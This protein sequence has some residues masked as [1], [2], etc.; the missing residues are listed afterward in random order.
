[1]LLICV[2]TLICRLHQRTLVT[3]GRLESAPESAHFTNGICDGSESPLPVPA[4]SIAQPH[5]VPSSH[6][7]PLSAHDVDLPSD[8]ALRDDGQAVTSDGSDV[9]NGNYL[10]SGEDPVASSLTPTSLS[11]EEAAQKPYFFDTT[12]SGDES[13]TPATQPVI[14]SGETVQSRTDAAAEYDTN[15][16]QAATP[17]EESKSDKAVYDKQDMSALEAG[18]K[19]A[20]S[21][22]ETEVSATSV[23]VKSVTVRDRAGISTELTSTIS[24]K[25][26][27]QH[28]AETTSDDMTRVFPDTVVVTEAEKHAKPSSAANVVQDAEQVTCSDAVSLKHV[29]SSV[30]EEM[31]REVVTDDHAVLKPESVSAD[32]RDDGL[33]T[34]PSNDI[35]H[36]LDD[37]PVTGNEQ[38]DVGQV[39]A[40]ETPRK[41][42]KRD[43]VGDRTVPRVACVI[44]SRT[45]AEPLKPLPSE[46]TGVQSVS[47]AVKTGAMAAVAAPYLAGKAIAD[48]LRSDTGQTT[49]V[50][51]NDQRLSEMTKT[52]AEDEQR[53]PFKVADAGTSRQLIRD[54]G[55]RTVP[56]HQVAGVVP[57]HVDAEPG[58]PLP[59]DNDSAVRRDQDWSRQAGIMA[60]AVVDETMADVD[61]V[62]DSGE[63]DLNRTSDERRPSVELPKYDDNLEDEKEESDD[64]D[65]D[66]IDSAADDDDDTTSTQMAP[67]SVK[68][69]ETAKDKKSTATTSTVVCARP[70]RGSGKKTSKA[71]SGLPEDV[72]GTEVLYGDESDKTKEGGDRLKHAFIGDG[73]EQKMTGSADEKSPRSEHADEL[74]QTAAVDFTDQDQ[75]FVVDDQHPPARH[76]KTPDDVSTKE[77]TVHSPTSRAETVSSQGIAREI[78]V[79]TDT[80]PYTVTE[81]GNNSDRVMEQ[82]RSDTATAVQGTEP[83]TTDHE[84]A[85]L[86]LQ[87]SDTE[88]EQGDRM[89]TPV[90]AAAETSALPEKVAGHAPDLQVSLAAKTPKTPDNLPA[91]PKQSVREQV[92]SA[93]ME[94]QQLDN[95]QTEAELA[96]LRPLEIRQQVDADEDKKYGASER[97]RGTDVAGG[98]RSVPKDKADN[99]GIQS[100]SKAVKTGAMAAVAAPYL[101]G[102]AIADALRSDTGSATSVP[103]NDQRLSETTKTSAEEQQRKPSSIGDDAARAFESHVAED[104]LR[105]SRLPNQLD[106]DVE[107]QPDSAEASDSSKTTVSSAESTNADVILDTSPSSPY[108]ASGISEVKLQQSLMEQA[109]AVAAGPDSLEVHD[110]RSAESSVKIEPLLP[111]VASAKPSEVT[112]ASTVPSVQPLTSTLVSEPSAIALSVSSETV[113]P[114]ISTVASTVQPPKTV[115]PDVSIAADAALSSETAKPVVSVTSTVPSLE[116][117]QPIISTAAPTLPYSASMQPTVST[118]AETVQPVVTTTT[119]AVPLSV[120]AEPFVSTTASAVQS[121]DTSKPIVSTVPMSETMQP[122]LSTTTSTVSSSET[123][124]PIVSTKESP[125]LPSETVQPVISAVASTPLPPDTLQAVIST[126]P[127][128]QQPTVTTQSVLPAP[129]SSHVSPSTSVSVVSAL[130]S[131]VSLQTTTDTTSSFLTTASI[132]SPVTSAIISE[133]F[134]I[135]SDTKPT[136]VVEEMPS[137]EMDKSLVDSSAVAAPDLRSQPLLSERRKAEVGDEMGDVHLE[138]CRQRAVTDAEWDE[139]NKARSELPVE[140]ASQNIGERSQPENEPHDSALSSVKTA[141]KMG[142]LGIVGAPV[143]AGKAIAEAVKSKTAEEQDSQ[144]RRSPE[145]YTEPDATKL[146]KPVAPLDQLSDD[147]SALAIT[148]S[149]DTRPSHKYTDTLAAFQAEELQPQVVSV[150]SR[151]VAGDQQK[152]LDADK[153]AKD[154]PEIAANQPTVAD[155][156]RSDFGRSVESTSQPGLSL[157]EA[158]LSR[159][160]DQEHNCFIDPSTG[161]RISLA[162]AVQ[163]GLIDGS[164]KVIA[165]LNSGE[166]ISVVEALSRGIIDPETGMV[167]V[168]GEAVVPLN[169]ALASGLIMDDTDGELLELAASIGAAAGRHAWNEA[170]DTA[171]STEELQK[172]VRSHR[173][174]VARQSSQPL[175]LVQMLDLGLYDPVSGEFRD[176]QTSDSL[177]LGEAIRWRLL[178]KNSV[179]INDPQS[180]EVLSLEESVRGGL[181]SG[182][183]SLVHD[184]STSENIPLTEA[185]RRGILVPRPMSI[186]TAINIG[187]YDEANGMFFDPTNGLYFALEEAVEGGLIDPHSLVIDPATGKAMAVAAALACGILDARHGNVVNIH[188]GEVIPLK[189]MA[190]SS[191]AVIGSQPVGISNQV[192]TAPTSVEQAGTP[193]SGPDVHEI[194]ESR[195]ISASESSGDANTGIQSL[196]K[197]IKTGALAAVAAPY[198]AG[199]AIADALRSDRGLT[200]GD[201]DKTHDVT[202][203][204]RLAT[205]SRKHDVSPT[206]QIND[207]PDMAAE[208]SDTSM[209]VLQGDEIPH[210][211]GL[212]RYT[213][214]APSA[215]A[216]PGE[217]MN[218]DVAPAGTDAGKSWLAET[219]QVQA[220]LSDYQPVSV[221]AE[222][223]AYHPTGEVIAPPAAPDASVSDESYRA[224]AFDESLTIP[225]GDESSQ[226]MKGQSAFDSGLPVSNV[227]GPTDQTIPKPFVSDDSG[228]PVSA[229]VSATTTS[230]DISP[231]LHPSI[232]VVPEDGGK[233]SPAVDGVSSTVPLQQILSPAA[234]SDSQVEGGDVGGRDAELQRS[235]EAE[236]LHDA[237]DISIAQKTEAENSRL[238]PDSMHVTV[239][240]DRPT[241][242]GFTAAKAPGLGQP[243][244]A[245]GPHDIQR[246][247]EMKHIEVKHVPG[248]VTRTGDA[249]TADEDRDSVSK[250]VGE[251]DDGTKDAPKKDVQK[252]ADFRD[253]VQPVT[254]V[255]HVDDEKTV[256]DDV[257]KS[258]IAKKVEERRDHVDEDDLK[259]DGSKKDIPGAMRDAPCG[260]E[261]VQYPSDVQIAVKPLSG[262]SVGIDA[263]RKGTQDGITK[264]KDKDVRRTDKEQKISTDFGES[265]DDVQQLTGVIDIEVKTLPADVKEKDSLKNDKAGSEDLS[266][267]YVKKHIPQKEERQKDAVAGV[268]QQQ[269]ILQQVEVTTV[270]GDVTEKEYVTDDV[271]RGDDISKDD[272]EKEVRQKVDAQNETVGVIESKEDAERLSKITQIE[273]KPLPEDAGKK[274]DVRTLKRDDVSRDDDKKDKTKKDAVQT[275]KSEDAVAV[276]DE[277]RDDAKTAQDGIA[278]KPTDVVDT[279]KQQQRDVD[280][281]NIDKPVDDKEELVAME[282]QQQQQKRVLGSEML[283]EETISAGDKLAVAEDDGHELQKKD[284]SSYD[285]LMGELVEQQNWLLCAMMTLCNQADVCTS[286]ADNSDVIPGHICHLQVCRS[287]HFFLS[288]TVYI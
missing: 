106:K 74:D 221:A 27:A 121:A 265:R 93:R 249:E 283:T 130:P 284:L 83:I 160:Y 50:S 242:V 99:T 142:L 168:D 280:T 115:Q 172:P 44:P 70:S 132:T 72:D 118:T 134:D 145:A 164:N 47:K 55:D 260:D 60:D 184:T 7:L 40:V 201:G 31:P 24:T 170:T 228:P 223:A 258:S 122:I 232:T 58:R 220:Q 195:I 117:A 218:E 197:V 207:V 15:G 126:V 235:V 189:Q 237:D 143:L 226:E 52:L 255:I 241:Q 20:P 279:V 178:D 211:D 91:V 125:L 159:L 62:M 89:H 288:V 127:L 123:A 256:P 193:T 165:D 274:E 224:P 183:T 243:Q 88:M 78:G 41:V 266:A 76:G 9:M 261:D 138:P 18:D 247:S 278:D 177:S 3:N 38:M 271:G 210:H 257:V 111:F 61:N 64:D 124:Q 234:T 116:P 84:D 2:C 272:S 73:E 56:Q 246:V 276:T 68:M 227:T 162:S 128:T 285:V 208:V 95:R 8:A 156:M 217:V 238:L 281:V 45:D 96:V 137:E 240:L 259:R 11:S 63:S 206:T 16:M 100:I 253:D 213:D 79:R 87:P 233:P 187:L 268:V 141:V 248:D 153:E 154:K 151:D 43:D 114:V 157:S 82:G 180:E 214:R 33:S 229:P 225:I 148:V 191:Q 176:P 149:T 71:S 28:P 267:V 161:R 119:S 175:K 98:R 67:R 85:T 80:R 163:L 263:V 53:K 90:L 152:E 192:T 49:S 51:R 146:Q 26:T 186:A 166:V 86:E 135:M 252:S 155:E 104:R 171:K 222:P 32:V 4:D 37:T 97:P 6:K 270:P 113:Q 198:I 181:V 182:S 179:V 105:P 14:S 140:Q 277:Y 147:Q 19:T 10:S 107:Q 35:S 230:L 133:E 120:T 144:T 30:N 185:L 203:D 269:S 5:T 12:V 244:A 102:K 167:L 212:Y 282:M 173:R 65:M 69:H 48:A 150:S 174:R 194:N 110:D 131:L 275:G 81:H 29:V 136:S 216:I 202:K 22:R 286:A 59:S 101:A 103:R 77:P 36:E 46:N 287:I 112:A 158:L 34:E 13:R 129:V 215:T 199:K 139:R 219:Q 25:E 264:E 250:D 236:P 262:S 75:S 169:E 251:K 57:S 108:Q 188:T 1:M 66:K 109:S 42:T 204:D 209:D 94:P 54:E 190:V 23:P 231:E 21:D 205:G 254:R 200:P 92:E 196:S 17:T 39:A 273:V 239:G 245:A